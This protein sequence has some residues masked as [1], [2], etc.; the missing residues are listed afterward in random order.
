MNTHPG[1]FHAGEV[2]RLSL[3]GRY[4]GADANYMVEAC[5]LCGLDE[6]AH[7]PVWDDLPPAPA[8][9]RETVET[10][11]R[12]V[13][14][15][16]KPVVIDGSKNPD[17]LAHLHDSGLNGAS[18]ILLSRNPLAFAHS[19]RDATGAPVWAG[20]EIWRNIYNHALRVLLHRQIP[21]I[22]LRHADLAKD[23]DGF[24]G[25][26]LEFT[27]LGGRVDRETFFKYETHALGG[28]VGAFVKYKRFNAER[29]AEQEAR[30][31]RPIGPTE[32]KDKQ[33]R[34]KR[35]EAWRDTAWMANIPDNE[36]GAALNIPGV[37]ET[38]SLLGYSAYGLFAAKQKWR[39]TQA[40]GALLQDGIKL[41][42]C[43]LNG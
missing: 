7:C 12:L 39:L 43:N 27:G 35:P 2:D 11:Q 31:N 3:F 9:A 26:I 15:G 6:H 16:G 37:T 30:A 21:F 1:I 28:N 38:M 40:P 24:Y 29:F 18:A 13:A 17:W 14:R 19:H 5:A 34:Q 8:T 42:R 32:L 23:P 41:L 33:T 20:V 10:Y 4:Q 36:A 25:R 22:S